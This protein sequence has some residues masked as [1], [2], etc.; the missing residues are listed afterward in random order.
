LVYFRIDDNAMSH[1]KIVALS[2]GAFRLWVAAGTHSMKYLTDGFV[3]EGVVKSA[4]HGKPSRVRELVTP[5]HG[6]E[7]GLWERVP[8]GYQFHDWHDSQ[9]A[10]DTV[11]KRRD[12]ARERMRERRG[13]SSR[14]RSAPLILTSSNEEGEIDIHSSSPTP[15]RERAESSPHGGTPVDNLMSAV[16][17]A[18]AESCGRELDRTGASAVI[19]FLDERR[20][21]SKGTPVKHP[22]RYYGQAI[23]RDWPEIQKF[24]DEQQLGLTRSETITL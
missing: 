19:L 14:E 12:G 24:I 18:A 4:L 11:I 3:A 16:I 9:E 1:P 21:R 22:A 2:D 20:G 7:V 17:A 8:G 10:A 6:Y 5:P 23:A 15:P 13:G